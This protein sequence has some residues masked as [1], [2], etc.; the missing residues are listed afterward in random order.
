MK[1]DTCEKN[2]RMRVVRDLT[3]CLIGKGFKLY[4]DN[5]FNS[6]ELQKNL[7]T[8]SIKFFLTVRKSRKKLP[9]DMKA[10]KKL[11]REEFDWRIMKDGIVYLKWKDSKGE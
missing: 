9:A 5:Y 7:L 11:E 3:G 2:L 1:V 8:D 4:F 6:I 10:D